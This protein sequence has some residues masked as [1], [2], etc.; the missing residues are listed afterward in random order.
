MRASSS[1]CRVAALGALFVFGAIG[2]SKAGAPTEG[3]P[4]S[5][6]AVHAPTQVGDIH[7]N[8]GAIIDGFGFLPDY[9]LGT[10]IRRDEMMEVCGLW[11]AAFLQCVEKAGTVAAELDRCLEH[12][13]LKDDKAATITLSWLMQVS[14]KLRASKVAEHDES[15]CSVT[16]QDACIRVLARDAKQGVAGW[17]TRLD[18]FL[19][20]ARAACDGGATGACEQ[21]GGSYE[22]AAMLHKGNQRGHQ[23]EEA[24]CDLGRSESCFWIG[25]RLR[26]SDERAALPFF[27][28]ACKAGLEDG[29]EAAAASRG[30]L[31]I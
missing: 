10:R 27:E 13:T 23:Y 31:A 22:R 12:S 8:C 28:R 29:C 16:E 5:E 15:T 2:C 3:A 24:A 18:D 19:V 14:A 30:R 17:E 20:R 11:S 9:P 26:S 21:L 25:Y 4:R 1:V 7:D 6:T